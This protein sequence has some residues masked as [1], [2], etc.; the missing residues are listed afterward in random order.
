MRRYIFLRL[1][2]AI[3]SMFLLSILVFVLVRASGD[4]LAMFL[5]PEATLEDEARLRV[6]FG[7]D[8]PL[9]VQYFL[10]VANAAKGNLG[11]SQRTDTPALELF[12]DRL[13]NS[14]RL[15]GLGVALALLIG[16]PLGLV[17]ALTRGTLLD[18][19][20]RVIAVFGQSVPSFWVGLVLIELFAVEW[21]LL[22]IG[23][24]GGLKHYIL[25]AFTLSLLLL[26]GITRLL[27]S[28]LLEI[29]N[30]DYIRMARSVGIP[31]KRVVGKHALRNALI[32]VVTFAGVYLALF[33]GGA[34]VVETV[35]TWPGVGRLVYEAVRFRDF[36]VIQATVLLVSAFVILI[37]L[38]VD[39]LYV[40]LD[41]RI[42]Y[43]RP[44]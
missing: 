24:T 25:P 43:G 9:H 12:L 15:A 41:P 19:L 26:G 17:A 20:A 44:S 38:L 8:Q 16:L 34:V 42:R 3:V 10:W 29:L 27:R 7:Y 11:N 6:A 2:Q 18:N 23:G 14:L 36:P 40:W 35:F 1:L 32:P 39:L 5:P 28:S 33:V 37:N 31:E 30:S 22:P 21:R 4:P 13:P